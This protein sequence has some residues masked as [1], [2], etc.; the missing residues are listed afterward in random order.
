MPKF[1]KQIAGIL[2]MVF[3]LFFAFKFIPIYFNQPEFD[4]KLDR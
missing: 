2:L 1:N 3:R 4:I